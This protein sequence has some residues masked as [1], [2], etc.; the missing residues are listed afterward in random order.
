MLRITDGHA[1]E[2]A[3]S[4]ELVATLIDLGMSTMAK[5]I[6]H[7]YVHPHCVVL[8]TRPMRSVEAP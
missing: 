8:G 5:R 2:F 3:S 1:L 4:D 7:G 6:D